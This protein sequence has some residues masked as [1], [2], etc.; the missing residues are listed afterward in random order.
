M[1]KVDV[2]DGV[3]DGYGILGQRVATHLY[4]VMNNYQTFVSNGIPWIGWH[5]V[6]R[7]LCLRLIISV[8]LGLP[9]VGRL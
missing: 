6:R 7:R 3:S 1:H 2:N 9:A 5:P 4:E 8:A